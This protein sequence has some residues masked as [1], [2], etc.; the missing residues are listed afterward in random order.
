[1]RGALSRAVFALRLVP[2][3]PSRCWTDVG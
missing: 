3:V 2:H 1:L